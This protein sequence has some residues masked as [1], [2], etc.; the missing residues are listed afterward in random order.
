MSSTIDKVD[1]VLAQLPAGGG[2]PLVLSL[3]AAVIG[4]VIMRDIRITLVGIIIVLAML[5]HVMPRGIRNVDPAVYAQYQSDFLGN[6]LF[7]F[8]L[9][10]NETE[11][12]LLLW[13]IQ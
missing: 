3:L 12:R 5:W 7:L 4:G 9:F 13:L 10:W 8:S 6:S 11:S 2:Q 1:K